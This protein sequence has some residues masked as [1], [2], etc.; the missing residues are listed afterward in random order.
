MRAHPLDEIDL[1]LLHALQKKGRASNV[2]LAEQ[3]GITAAPA[4]RRTKKLEEC[5]FIR[6]Y[7]RGGI[8]MLAPLQVFASPTSEMPN[9]LARVF[10]GFDQTSA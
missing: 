3:V 6:G 10:I 9:S 7:P 1:H 2:A 5:G 4:L 8:G